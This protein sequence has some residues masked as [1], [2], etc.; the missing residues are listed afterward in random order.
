MIY[1][2]KFEKVVSSTEGDRKDGTGKWKKVSF[3]AKDKT[4]TC[5]MCWTEQTDFVLGLKQGEKITIEC[6]VESREFNGKYYTDAIARKVSF[7]ESDGAEKTPLQQKQEA[8]VSDPD[9]DLPF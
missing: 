2:G 1:T 4:L 3:L 8:A 6:D 9:N 7:T 5:F